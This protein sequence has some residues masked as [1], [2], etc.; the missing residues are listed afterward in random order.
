MSATDVP[1]RAPL[2]EALRLALT[3]F[4]ILMV[5]AVLGAVVLPGVPADLKEGEQASGAKKEAGKQRPSLKDSWASFKWQLI[6]RM[7]IFAACAA[8]AAGLGRFIHRA[9]TGPRPSSTDYGWQIGLLGALLATGWLTERDVPAGPRINTGPVIELTGPGLN[10]KEISLAQLRGKVV[11]VDFWATWCPPCR[12]EMPNMKSIYRKHHENGLEIVGVS[13]D[14]ER[15]VLETYLREENIPW[16]QIYFDQ[17]D[18]QGWGNPVAR[19][20][21]VHAIPHT[22]LVDREGRLASEDL[23]GSELE[24]AVAE[25]FGQPGSTRFDL[26]HL[27]KRLFIWIL[28][29]LLQSTLLLL[30][31]M[32]IGC[33][34]LGSAIEGL[35]VRQRPPAILPH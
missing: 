31:P 15:R 11:I 14:E 33:A 21:G 24:S 3:V 10:G 28:A 8:V 34:A 25:Q 7:A 22:L 6:E 27:F 32:A 5:V 20:F 35:I 19:K 2:A 30:A 18:K 1:Q 23:R 4:V 17:P 9:M 29:A 16:P 12:G 26:I 13:L